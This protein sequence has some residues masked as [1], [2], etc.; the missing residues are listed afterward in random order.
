MNTNATVPSQNP[1]RSLWLS[2]LNV[3]KPDDRKKKK[4]KPL[5]RTALGRL[6]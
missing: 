3:K 2:N 1:S 4:K 5:L 6:T